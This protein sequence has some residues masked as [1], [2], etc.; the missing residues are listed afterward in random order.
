MNSLQ[1]P[2]TFN[3]FDCHLSNASRTCCNFS[4]CMT[5]E[6]CSL[7]T[8]FLFFRFFP[9]HF[10]LMSFIFSSLWAYVVIVHVSVCCHLL[11]KT[12]GIWGRKVDMCG[13][14]RSN[15]LS[16]HF[17]TRPN[18]GHMVCLACSQVCI[19]LS[20]AL[21]LLC[22]MSGLRLSPPVTK[23]GCVFDF[24]HSVVCI[25]C[26]STIFTGNTPLLFVWPRV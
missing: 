1:V 20:G 24:N 9:T 3:H 21:F 17:M 23:R 5:L 7:I 8:A 26:L 10:L 25:F 2:H 16:T 14:A 19:L 12:C 11:T 18:S 15:V 6:N 13:M 4:H 22:L